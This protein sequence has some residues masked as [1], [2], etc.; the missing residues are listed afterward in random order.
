MPVDPDRTIAELVLEEPSR[1]RELERLGLDYCCGG[2]RSLADACEAAGVDLGSTLEALETAAGDT[3]DEP[4]WQSVPLSELVDHIVS[5]HH[6]RLRQ[7]LPRLDGLLAKVVR[8][9][10]DEDPQ[11]RELQATFVS[12]RAELEEHMADEEERLFPLCRTGE[13]L[14]PRHVAELEDEHAETGLALAQLRARTRD[15][16]L[17]LARCNTHRAAIDGLR[18]LELDLHR[19]IHEENNVLFARALARA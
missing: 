18:E 7:E 17:D 8:A 11:L 14:D 13:P 1:A 9:H 10:A 6:D 16:D 15:Y 2:K 3:S 4:D 5:A 12:L 19:H